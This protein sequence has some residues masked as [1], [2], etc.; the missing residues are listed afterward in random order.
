MCDCGDD[1]YVP[2][3]HTVYLSPALWRAIQ[4]A[5]LPMLSVV[6]ERAADGRPLYRLASE[7]LSVKD[8]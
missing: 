1:P 8:E 2:N 5:A 3:E 4:S 7:R 6:Q